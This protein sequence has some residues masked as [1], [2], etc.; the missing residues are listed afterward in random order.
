MN[1][2]PF[3]IKLN[4][5]YVERD[6]IHVYDINDNK[7]VIKGYGYVKKLILQ[8]R[9]RYGRSIRLTFR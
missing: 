2:D 8:E 1:I 5:I 7:N 6:Y 3:S 9:S 4:N